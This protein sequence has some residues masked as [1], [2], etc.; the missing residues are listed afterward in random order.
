[1]SVLTLNKESE[2]KENRFWKFVKNFS[3]KISDF[4]ILTP[5]H[6]DEIGI[7]TRSQADRNLDKTGEMYELEQENAQKEIA[8]L[9][10]KDKQL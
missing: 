10:N 6:N 8:K 3:S 7:D 1:M 9:N 4:F 5:H 2:S